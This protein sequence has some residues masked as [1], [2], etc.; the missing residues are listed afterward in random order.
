M[1]VFRN[2]KVV[3]MLE[4]RKSIKILLVSTICAGHQKQTLPPRV[5]GLV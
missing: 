4:N 1:Y 2:A 5:S 3:M